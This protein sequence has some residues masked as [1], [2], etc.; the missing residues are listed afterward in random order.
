MVAGAEVKWTVIAPTSFVV[1]EADTRAAAEMAVLDA[2]GLS[3]RVWLTRDWIVRESTEDD[4]RRYSAAVD[5]LVPP[6]KTATTV[7]ARRKP[8]AE[9]MGLFDA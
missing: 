2:A 3:G 6:Q 1:V 4:V 5:G 8:T 9:R 7:R